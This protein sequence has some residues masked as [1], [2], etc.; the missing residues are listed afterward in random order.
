[1]F[2]LLRVLSFRVLK[3][4]AQYHPLDQFSSVTQSCLT[5]C[6]P[7]DFNTPGFLS[8]TNSWSLPKLMSFGVVM[9]SNHLI[10]CHPFLLLLSIFLSIRIFPISWFFASGGQNIEV[11]ASASVL[12]M[13][14]QNWLPLGLTGWI[15][16]QSKGLSRVFS[17]TTVQK[18]QFFSASFV[19]KVMSLLFNIL[20]R[21]VIAFLPRSKSLLMS[22]LQLPSAVILELPLQKKNQKSLTV[23][24]FPHLFAKKWWNQVPWS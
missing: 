22:W 14:I 1:M 8:I 10:L 16:L 23:P 15:S 5:L 9:P 21:L 7:M 4:L 24:L 2:W 17:N 20:Y 11:S 12:L 18:H 19:G 6:D 13:N 3:C